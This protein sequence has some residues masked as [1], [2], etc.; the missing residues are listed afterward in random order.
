MAMRASGIRDIANVLKVSA[1]IVILTLRL[2]FK[3]HTE[4]DFKA[5]YENVILDELW[6]WVGKRKQGKRWV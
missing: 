6:S 2:W 4:P 3:T 5:T 1:V